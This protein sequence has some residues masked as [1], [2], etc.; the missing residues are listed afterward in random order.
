MIIKCDYGRMGNR[1]HTHANA[2]AWCIQNNYNLLNLSFT[3]YSHFFHGKP[4]IYTYSSD[5]LSFFLS[6]NFLKKLLSKICMSM[7]WLNRF[8]LIFTTIH[9]SDTECLTEEELNHISKKSNFFLIVKAW[10]LDFRYSLTS[11]S[12]HVRSI[13]SPKK[14]ISVE[15]AKN[16]IHK[17]KSKHDCIV[18]V[19]ARRGDYK[20]YLN[21]KH[22]HSWFDYKNWIIQSKSV[23]CEA[24]YKRPYFIVCSDDKTDETFF[25]N[26]PVYLTNE[27]DPIH[28][29]H[30]L[31]LCD[32]NF[33][34][35]SSF[36]TWISWYG[37]VSRAIISKGTRI[38]SIKQFTICESC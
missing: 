9:R 20:N 5:L 3:E 16:K 30:L 18:G 17:L 26:L 15:N 8:S 36:G 14:N 7:K 28:D 1:L 10:D 13:L 31:S 24:G 6:K 22:Y 2:L 21:G 34:P 27:N 12:I 33:G 11:E 37:N 19:H 25:L 32:F 35:P 29:L 38:S 4:D 23:F